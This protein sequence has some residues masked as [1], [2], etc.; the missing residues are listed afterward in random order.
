MSISQLNEVKTDQVHEYMKSVYKKVEERNEG[1][2]EFLQA[3][4]R[5]LIQLSR[6]Y[7]NIPLI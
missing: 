2:Y 7:M 6:F 1:E 3:V 4:R 5:F